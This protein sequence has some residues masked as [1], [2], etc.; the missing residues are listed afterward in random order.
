MAFDPRR[1]VATLNRHE[2]A[3]I[4]VGGLAAVAHGSPL[5][6]ED[7]DIAPQRSAENFERLA[8]ALRELGARLRVSEDLDGVPFPISS[9]FLTAQPHR[10]NLVT[11]AGDLDLTITPSGFPNGYDDLLAG[12]VVVDLGDGSPTRIAS[13]VDVITSKRAAGRA[14]DLAAL[15]YLRALAEELGR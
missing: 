9:A 15:P 13:L 4:V 3:F 6:T 1:V 12:S 11:D 10:L 14:K 7:I 8:D 2:V 5:P